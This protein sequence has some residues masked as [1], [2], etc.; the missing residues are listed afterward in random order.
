VVSR[1]DVWAHLSVP[2]STGWS[3]CYGAK[4]APICVSGC[5]WVERVELEIT[6]LTNVLEAITDLVI[7]T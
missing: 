6:L 4:G 3:Q 1:Q 5:V 7:V 2:H